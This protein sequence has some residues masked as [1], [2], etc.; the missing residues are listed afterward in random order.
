M[1]LDLAE[2]SHPDFPRELLAATETELDKVTRLVEGG[3][4]AGA[5]KIGVRVGK[6]LGRFK[7]AKHFDL[8]ITD[9]SFSHARRQAQIAA[10]A[11]LDGIYV[12]RTSVA[13]DRL[14]APG[15]VE[16]YQRLAAVERD[17]RS[18]KSIDLAVRPIHHRRDGRVRAH[19]RCAC[20]P[21][22]WSG[23]CAGRWPR[24]ASPTRPH[25][26]APIR[27]PPPSAR[28][29][30]PPRPPATGC[31]TAPPPTAS[32]ACWSIWPP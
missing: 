1:R 5:A 27:S 3:K 20:W 12:I 13:A 10:E 11:A 19:V 17:F 26:S 25:P 8:E 9:T 16:A 21:A 7:V 31:P 18:L 23:T 4:L 22:T 2:I 32:A 14:D 6:V 29:P 28:S 30:R 24:C 15:V